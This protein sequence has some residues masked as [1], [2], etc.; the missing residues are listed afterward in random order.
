MARWSIPV[1]LCF[2][3]FSYFNYFLLNYFLTLSWKLIPEV[4]W[5]GR[6][7]SR[8][9]AGKVLQ[10]EQ[11]RIWSLLLSLSVSTF[12]PAGCTSAFITGRNYKYC[13]NNDHAGL[14]S[15][16]IRITCGLL[17]E[18]VAASSS[19]HNHKYLQSKIPSFCIPSILKEECGQLTSGILTSLSKVLMNW[20][21]FHQGILGTE[22][23]SFSLMI[24]MMTEC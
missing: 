20:N 18:W 17:R 9:T 24:I 3:L 15:L 22:K 7:V 19:W 11:L 13:T 12:F 2:E 10:H 6:N 16:L 8:S 23:G 14:A 5:A 1:V 4:D 21:C